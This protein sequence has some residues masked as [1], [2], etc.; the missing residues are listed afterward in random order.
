MTPSCKRPINQNRS[1]K[2][3]ETGKNDKNANAK[4]KTKQGHKNNYNHD[5]EP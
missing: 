5:R 2:A 3:T 1:F 4:M